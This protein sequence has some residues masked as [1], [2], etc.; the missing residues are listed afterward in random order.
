MVHVT[1][2]DEANAPKTLICSGTMIELLIGYWCQKHCI[3]PFFPEVLINMVG[4]VVTQA[5]LSPYQ[6]SVHSPVH[7]PVQSPE[8]SFYT[9]RCSDDHIHFHFHF[10]LALV[11]PFP[12]FQFL[13]SHFLFPAFSYTRPNQSPSGIKSWGLLKMGTPVPWN[14]SFQ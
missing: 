6:I 5:R 11:F 4:M 10:H 13:I 7:S 9:Y 3:E 2:Y 1:I 8:S 12:R 14:H